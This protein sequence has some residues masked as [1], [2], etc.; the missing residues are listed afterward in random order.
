MKRLTALLVS[1]LFISTTA[2][3]QLQA[4]DYEWMKSIRTDHPRMFFT[5]EDLPLMVNNSML[6]DAPTYN[7]MQRRIDRIIRNGLSEK[8]ELA[9]NN[10]PM[11]SLGLRAADAAMLWA[12]TKNPK[13]LDF[14]KF[15]LRRVIE[16]YELRI[17][18]NLEV[19]GQAFSV[20]STLWAYDWLYNDLTA[21]ERAELGKR[22]YNVT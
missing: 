9:A 4:K 15:A 5:A 13:Y 3:A 1:L 16:N 10:N 14:A 22:L 11:A 6:F 7:V 18:N 2:F 8:S 21:E 17:A 12:I 20:I 19:S